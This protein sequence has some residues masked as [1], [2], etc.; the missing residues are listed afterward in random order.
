MTD[1]VYTAGAMEHVSQEN[2]LGWRRYVEEYLEPFEIECL[3][4][5]RRMPLHE[6]ENDEGDMS[7]Y[8]RLKRIE[9]QDMLDIKASKVIFADLRDSMPG[10]KWGTVIEVAKAKEWGK[11]VIALVDRG[12]FKHPFIYAYAT[13]V[14]H[15][16]EDAVEAVLEYYD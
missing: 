1:Y 4:P 16:I 12:Q 9:A 8:N 15:N 11:V 7:T 2:M 10:K 13:E 5:T 3:H 6:Q 14:H